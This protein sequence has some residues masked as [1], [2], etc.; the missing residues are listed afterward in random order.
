MVFGPFESRID[1]LI[2]AA[3]AG[4]AG[5]HKGGKASTPAKR[6]AARANGKLGGRRPTRSLCELLLHQKLSR[7]QKIRLLQAWANGSVLLEREKQQFLEYFSSSSEYINP[8]INHPLISDL[9]RRKSRKPP[10]EIRFLIT[11]FRVAARH[12][13][14]VTPRR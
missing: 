14:A 11:K 6:R 3:E 10:K 5:G 1:G 2:Y 9:W 12:Y 13:M 7:D 8:T 4:R